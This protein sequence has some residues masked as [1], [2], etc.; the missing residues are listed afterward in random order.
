MEAPA[1]YGSLEERYQLCIVG[2]LGERASELRLGYLDRRCRLRRNE[3]LRP[4][5]LEANLPRRARTRWSKR[6]QRNQERR[7]QSNVCR[8][9]PSLGQF[10]ISRVGYRQRA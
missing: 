4:L 3:H 5:E 6:E 1:L 8:Q 9:T 7:C 10:L 2:E